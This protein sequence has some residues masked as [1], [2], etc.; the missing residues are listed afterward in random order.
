MSNNINKES[1][2]KVINKHF[3]PLEDKISN[4]SKELVLKEIENLPSKRD[5]RFSPFVSERYN[6]GKYSV[7]EYLKGNLKEFGSAENDEYKVAILD[8][9]KMLYIKKDDPYHLVPVGSWMDW[10]EYDHEKYFGVTEKYY[11]IL[12]INKRAELESKLQL[13]LWID[14]EYYSDYAEFYLPQE[15][16]RWW[17]DEGGADKQI[18]DFNYSNEYW[19]QKLQINKISQL[20]NSE[21]NVQDVM[22]KQ[23]PGLLKKG[24]ESVY[25]PDKYDKSTLEIKRVPLSQIKPTQFGGDYENPSSEYEAKQF[26]DV[27]DG[28]RTSEDVRLENFYPLLVDEKTNRIIDGNHRHYAL[29]KINSPYAVV[30]YVNPKKENSSNQLTGKDIFD[31]TTTGMSYYNAMIQKGHI[32][33]NRDPVEYF[34][35]NKRLVFEIVWMSPEEYLERAYKIHKKTSLMYSGLTQLPFETYL[36]ININPDLIQEYTERTL[37]GSKMPMPVLDYDKLTQEGRHRAVVAQQLNVEEIPVLIV[38]TYEE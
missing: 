36:E 13:K 8:N 21:L 38:R 7:K 2:E 34:K 30:L 16:D 5:S 31:I 12:S 1:I 9:F 28:K 6:E 15:Y 10:W 35:T 14:R 23:V 18:K 20:T 4:L 33:G 25:I 27:L 29:S 19:K 37:E 32:V 24:I 11:K 3:N 22:Y 26:Q 17:W